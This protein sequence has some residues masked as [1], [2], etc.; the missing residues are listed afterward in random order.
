M[1]PFPGT[2][3]SQLVAERSGEEGG[4]KLDLE[5]GQGLRRG[6]HTGMREGSPCCGAC[7]EETGRSRQGP[8]QVR[9][10]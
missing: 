1:I 3:V 4:Q 10:L 7:R 6:Q 9:L 2:E 5:G 8:E